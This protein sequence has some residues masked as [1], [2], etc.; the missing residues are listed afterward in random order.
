MRCVQS[1][2]CIMLLQCFASSDQIL[3]TYT[4]HKI[5][6]AE[7]L[8]GRHLSE[9]VLLPE[10]LRQAMQL[11]A[12]CLCASLVELQTLMDTKAPLLDLALLLL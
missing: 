5:L 8:A 10:R 9:G 7:E 1:P 4:S 12:V 2:V 11:P 3:G 6:E